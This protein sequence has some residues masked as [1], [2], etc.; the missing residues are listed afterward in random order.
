MT[1]ATET[2]NVDLARQAC[3]AKLALDAETSA[4]RLERA[5]KRHAPTI[6]ILHRLEA[7]RKRQLFLETGGDAFDRHYALRGRV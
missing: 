6:R 4:Q 2:R 1:P 3:L 7:I 5:R